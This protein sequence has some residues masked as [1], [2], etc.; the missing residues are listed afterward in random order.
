MGGQNDQVLRKRI[1]DLLDEPE[2]QEV[3]EKPEEKEAPP[4]DEQAEKQ[5]VE[6]P[7]DV[8][9]EKPGLGLDDDDLDQLDADDNQDD[10]DQD[11]NPED[12]NP[13]DED[14]ALDAKSMA[15][16]LGISIEDLY[17]IE[18]NYADG[19]SLTLGQLKDAGDRARGADDEA[20]KL[21]QDRERLDNDNMKARAEIQNIVSLL[22]VEA[23]DPRLIQQAQNQHAELVRSERINVISA[24][25]GWKDPAVEVEDRAAMMDILGGYGFKRVEAD[26]MLDHR[27]IKLIYDH[28]R[29]R[30]KLKPKVDEIKRLRKKP[31]SKRPGPKGSTARQRE[32]L[33]KAKGLGDKGNTRGAI[34]AIF[35]E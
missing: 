10:D 8:D 2:K 17:Q 19:E 12:E 9:E 22:P 26:N 34:D 4:K 32:R 15:E 29:L 16:K 11:E 31:G 3:V 33:A 25:P 20:E 18:F 6:K 30:A 28:T 21:S 5:Q 35:E 1:S 27:L 14:Q 7:K 24:I 13:E 23:I